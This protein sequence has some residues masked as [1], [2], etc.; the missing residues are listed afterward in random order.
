MINFSQIISTIKDPKKAGPILGV[1]FIF[2]WLIPTSE[3]VTTSKHE[4]GIES[5]EKVVLARG[6]IKPAKVLPIKSSISDSKAKLTFLAEEGLVVEQGSVIAR[7]DDSIFVERLQNDEQMLAD[8]QTKL[9]LL[10]KQ[11]EILNEEE[12]KKVESAKK[13]LEISKLRVADM[14]HGQGP[15]AREIIV[16]ELGQ[17]NRAYS[18]ANAE[19]EDFDLMLEKGHVSQREY[20]K[21][22]D[23]VRKLFEQQQ[24]KQRQLDN[25]DK[26]EWPKIKRQAEIAEEQAYSA[27]LST[28][29][30]SDIS[31]HQFGNRVIKAQR[32]IV[33][34]EN[35]ISQTKSNIDSCIVKAPITG[36]LFHTELP[37]A[38]GI[39]KIQ[40]GDNIFAGQ[41][42]MQ[43][44]DT[45][46]LIFEAEIREFDLS[47]VTP[48]QNATIKL[49]AFPNTQMQAE[50]FKVNK[51]A[52]ENS[53]QI[54]RFV[55]SLLITEKNR[56]A[57]V[58]MYGQASIIV[59]AV[60]GKLAIP[61]QYVNS[62]SGYTWVN[63][64][65]EGPKK[66]TTGLSNNHWIE[67]QQG[68]SQGQILVH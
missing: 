32:D 64:E 43:I 7:F 67:V 13:E 15:M 46:Q 28:I 68:L 45:K 35:K 14:L 18:I 20:E 26:Y 31:I 40:V 55:A 24:L 52:K 65:G 19:K 30:I 5:F 8:A 61:L 60:N 25:F 49:D 27:Y 58:G 12:T 50:V 10:T 41:T 21:V 51:V 22:S 56:Q 23:S 42:F 33:R 16:V 4:V 44:P 9:D 34:I 11:L 17:A 63:V 36:Q 57:H 2:W 1:L 48:T 47:L 53:Q 66:I 39:R 59:G 37:R 38:E 54:N 3:V 29:K 6:E 62:T